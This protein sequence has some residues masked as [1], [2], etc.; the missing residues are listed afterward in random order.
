MASA[1]A[2]RVDWVDLRRV[3]AL[4]ASPGRLGMT[5]LPG[6]DEGPGGSHHRDLDRDVGRLRDVYSVDTV[7]LLVEDHELE[8]LRVPD[9]A[10]EMAAHGIDL[11]R[12]PIPDLG[13]PA[14]RGAFRGTLD[15]IRARLANGENV[16]V[17]C[18]GGL[19][20]TG[21]VVGCLL[22]DGGLDGD[23]A[24]ALTR[25]SRHGAIETVEQERF[26]GSWGE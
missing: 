19:G 26:V 1:G 10:D 24:I 3:P 4:A 15:D 13:F 9:I 12:H 16:V 8:R 2:I 11:V 7:V 18:R 6:K 17:V 5:F 14:D 22:R 25:A 20:R 23:A 21:T